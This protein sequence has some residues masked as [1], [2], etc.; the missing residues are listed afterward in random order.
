MAPTQPSPSSQPVSIAG[1]LRPGGGGPVHLRWLPAL[2][3]ARAPS[4]SP[5]VHGPT[6][7]G[8]EDRLQ[9]RK[10]PQERLLGPDALVE[11][12]HGP[13]GLTSGEHPHPR[14]QRNRPPPR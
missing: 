3:G 4:V 5:A 11:R 1:R 9:E 14:D 12:D 6:V 10:R 8:R 7:V 13:A 2:A